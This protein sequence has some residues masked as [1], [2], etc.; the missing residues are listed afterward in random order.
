MQYVSIY[1]FCHCVGTHFV[2]FQKRKREG[3]R[4]TCTQQERDANILGSNPSIGCD[5]STRCRCLG[6]FLC[7]SIA[8]KPGGGYDTVGADGWPLM[9]PKR[10]QEVRMCRTSS[11]A[12]AAA[13]R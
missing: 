5:A 3:L 7:A 13:A 8:V 12:A 2:V 6:L 9:G 11:C 1:S 10:L 4:S